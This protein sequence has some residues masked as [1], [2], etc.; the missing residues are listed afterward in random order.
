LNSTGKAEAGS[1]GEQLARINLF[2]WNGQRD[3]GNLISF[4]LV[5]IPRVDA[6]KKLIQ[7]IEL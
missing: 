4:Y 2:D 3:W 7:T 5:A 1:A 6:S